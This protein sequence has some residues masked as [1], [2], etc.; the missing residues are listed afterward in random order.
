LKQKEEGVKERLTYLKCIEKGMPRHGYDVEKN[1]EKIGRISSG[2]LSPC[3]NAGIAMAYVK[4]EYRKVGDILN[5]VIRNKRLKAEIVK[6]PFVGKE[7]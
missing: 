7:C 6:P 4:T 2:G 1:G 5:I 3:L